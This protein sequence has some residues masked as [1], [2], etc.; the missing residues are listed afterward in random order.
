FVHKMKQD[1]PTVM[2]SVKTGDFKPF[3][4]WLRDNVQSKGCLYK[5]QELVEK[6]TGRKMSTHFFKKHVTER[7]LE[8]AY[9]GSC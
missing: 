8:K 1:I 4:G 6:V 5:P 2:Q 3:N 7:Y 9:E